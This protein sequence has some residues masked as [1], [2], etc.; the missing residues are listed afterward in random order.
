MTPL[1]DIPVS[2]RREIMRIAEAMAVEGGQAVD[3]LIGLEHVARL[4]YAPLGDT[5]SVDTREGH[6][7]A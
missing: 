3:I 1:Y 2:R 7:E 5:L 6:F 4:E